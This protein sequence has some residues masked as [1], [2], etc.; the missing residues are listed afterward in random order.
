MRRRDV[1]FFGRTHFLVD[2]VEEEEDNEMDN[3][4]LDT[5]DAEH[6]KPPLQLF[7]STISTNLLLDSTLNLKALSTAVCVRCSNLFLG[8]A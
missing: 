3:K 5:D 8:L 7:V 2:K 6:A 1:E 4:F